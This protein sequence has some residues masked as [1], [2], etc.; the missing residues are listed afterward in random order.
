MM[1]IAAINSAVP[2]APMV[3]AMA[4]NDLG[5]SL[6]PAVGVGLIVMSLMMMLRKR[7]REIRSGQRPTARGEL[8]RLQQ[9]KAAAGDLGQLMA[10]IEQLA[11]RFGA[12]LDAKSIQLEQLLHEADQRIALLRQME[13]LRESMPMPADADAAPIRD[14]GPTSA[15]A[16]LQR[17]VY[18]LADEGL[19]ASDIAERLDEHHGKVELMLA[20]RKEI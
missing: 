6:I 17:Q 11:R 2:F 20:L 18:D 7:K 3:L 4:L 14:D 9:H 1:L 10:D 15:E 13:Q 12:Q 8:E 5:V 16:A 19:S